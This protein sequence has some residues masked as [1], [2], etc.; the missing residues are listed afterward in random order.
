MALRKAG[1]NWVDGDRFFD[2]ETELEALRERVEDGAHTLLTAQRRM[3][4]TSLVREL[5]RRLDEEATFETVF[6]DL[7]A[8]GGPEDAVAEIAVQSK[9]VRGAWQAIKSTFANTLR[10]A[11]DQIDE[12]ALSELKIKLRAGMNP[13]D[14]RHK[15]DL[16]FQA[17]ASTKKPVVL[18]IDEL[19]IL[20]SRLLKGRDNKI[21]AERTQATEE[22]L[23]WLRKNGQAHRGQVCLILS[24]SVGLHPI[25]HQV[26]LTAQAN[27]YNPFDLRPWNEP[28]ATECLAELAETYELALAPEIRADMCRRLRCLVP[29]HVQQFFD[30]LHE[31]LRR[32]G[33]H[34]ATL[35]DVAHVYKQELLGVRG[36]TAL[37]HYESRLKL[38]LDQ[39][40]YRAALELLTEAAT[41]AGR[42]RAEAIALYSD[43]YGDAV[44]IQNVLHVLDHDGYLEPTDD[45]Y[46]FVSALLEDWWRARHGRHFVSIAERGA[47]QG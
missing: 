13:G 33:R 41:N 10:D 15:G 20:T 14:W 17:L 36:Q 22:F 25:L 26:G 43:D 6:V 4:K 2:R 35:D 38:V 9:S 30:H 18:A 37:D 16:I 44:P 46:R 32:H 5:L 11:R 31:H 28:T 3:G 1:S 8:A 42:L 21:T 27:I 29:H 7:E 45:G 19:P 23:S 34:N 24:G 40:G 12:L 47:S 39:Q